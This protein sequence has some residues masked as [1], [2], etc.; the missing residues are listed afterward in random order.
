MN[1]F[2][3]ALFNT[4]SQTISPCLNKLS[5]SINIV[6]DELYEYLE[7]GGT[8]YDDPRTHLLSHDPTGVS[9]V[10]PITDFEGLSEIPGRFPKTVNLL[11]ELFDDRFISAHISSLSPGTNF[12]AHSTR[13]PKNM[14]VYFPLILPHPPF[15]SGVWI[16]GEGVRHYR[17]GRW[18]IHSLSTKHSIFNYTSS[19]TYVLVVDL[20]IASRKEVETDVT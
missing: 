6:L 1:T 3:E 17:E 4:A 12:K 2:K 15:S 20:K 10:L 5:G 14:R 19:E 18:C 9:K 8:F 13:T 7:D 16:D 11:R